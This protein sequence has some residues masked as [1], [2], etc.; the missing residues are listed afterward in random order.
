MESTTNTH[1]T[2]DTDT[3]TETE[4]E[5]AVKL[6]R[7]NF[8]N[9]TTCSEEHTLELMNSLYFMYIILTN[10][11]REKQLCGEESHDEFMMIKVLFYPGS[12]FRVGYFG[13]IHGLWAI[14]LRNQNHTYMYKKYESLGHLIADVPLIWARIRV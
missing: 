10:A 14:M 3:D 4:A 5:E 1:V 11:L 8:Q 2:P 7:E 13:R 6:A 9:C 12:T